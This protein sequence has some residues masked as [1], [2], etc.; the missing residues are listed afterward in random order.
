M[1]P[2]IQTAMMPMTMLLRPPLS[3]MKLPVDRASKA[4][5]K[6]R[7]SS[8]NITQWNPSQAH[9]MAFPSILWKYSDRAGPIVK[10]AVL[11]LIAAEHLLGRHGLVKGHRKRVFAGFADELIEECI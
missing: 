1:A 4:P 10:A 8:S 7:T 2:I 5:T 11:D 9:F 3:W 6:A